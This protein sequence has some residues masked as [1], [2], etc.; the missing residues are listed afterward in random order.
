VQKAPLIFYYG[1]ASPNP[2]ISQALN[3]LRGNSYAP[4]KFSFR[5]VK[6]AE[7]ELI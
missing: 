6:L 7:L 4:G 1:D 2:A 3:L 5:R